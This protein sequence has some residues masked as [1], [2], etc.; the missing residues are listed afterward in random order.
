MK[1]GPLERVQLLNMVMIR[2]GAEVLV[3]DKV[4]REG[5]EG[6][7]FPGGK[8]E[9][10]EA[11]DDSVRRE[12][13]EE[14]GLTL[15]AVSLVGFCHWI[16]PDGFRQIGMLYVSDDFSGT[17]VESNEGTLTWMDF[18]KFLQTE[19]K[20]DSMNEMLEIYRGKARE[21]RIW[22]DAEGKKEVRYTV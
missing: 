5:W 20:S 7:T 13:W 12:A 10:A 18:D 3:L 8:V 9:S 16:H 19:P 21:V 4:K 14:T 1:K 17:V 11:F 22:L 15:G 6:L 2:R